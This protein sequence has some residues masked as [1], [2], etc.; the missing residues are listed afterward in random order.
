MINSQAIRSMSRLVVLTLMGGGVI[1]TA[2]LAASLTGT[3]LQDD[4]SPLAGAAVSAQL[5]RSSTAIAPFRA[6]AATQSN[7]SFTISGL[8]TGTF[9]ICVQPR[10]RVLLSNCDWG[11]NDTRVTVGTANIS[12]PGI[13]L[14][15]GA[16]IHVR[17][18]DTQ[19][20]LVAPKNA[21]NGSPITKSDPLV[22]L[23]LQNG[24]F[25]PL[26]LVSQDKNGRDFELPIPYGIQVN[27]S[28]HGGDF[29]MTD[30]KGVSLDPVK[31]AS[32]PV[33]VNTGS[34]P[35]MIFDVVGRVSA[36]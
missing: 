30:S 22:G 18:S 6:D 36:K 14:Q 29:Q 35:V 8:G 10:S 7:G 17:I 33:Q 23:W 15:R 24:L 20:L 28:V 32:I 25:L 26:P 27:L 13:R 5:Q 4:G 2:G 16:P 21:N 9:Q 1:S 31:G 3:V 12:I 19:Q 34:A 11:L